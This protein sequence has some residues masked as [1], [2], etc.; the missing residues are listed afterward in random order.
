[1]GSEEQRKLIKADWHS[2]WKFVWERDDPYHCREEVHLDRKTGELLFTK[3]STEPSY[4][5]E[6]FLEQC[7][8]KIDSDPARYE[9]IPPISH[10]EHH[11]IFSDWLT[12]IPEE[13][14]VL[15]NIASIGHFFETCEYHFGRYRAME[16]RE[17]WHMFHEQS[18]KERAVEWARAKG[19]ALEWV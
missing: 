15:C 9:Y 12:T 5:E 1:M 10:A 6:E 11:E 3:R 18:L 8:S 16:L 13:I 14:K 4:M 17:N 2:L 7:Q 19:L